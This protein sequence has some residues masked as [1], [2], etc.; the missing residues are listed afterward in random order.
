[1]KRILIVADTHCGHRA[2]LTPPEWHY[3]V[4]EDAPRGIRKRAEQRETLWNWFAKNVKAQGKFHAL[5]HLGDC[6]DGKGERSEGTELITSDREEQCRMAAQ[7]IKFANAA[8]VYMVRGTPYHTGAGEDWED[9]VAKE[10]GA[11]KIEDEGH[12]EVNGL[13]I[14]A[15][16]F[17]GNSASIVSKATAA[18]RAQANQQLWAILGQQDRAHI[19]LRAHI[20]RYLRVD[21][22]FGT[23]AVCPPL[24]GL[25]SRF[26]VRQR[27]GLPCSFGFLVLD[28]ESAERWALRRVLMPLS[29]QRGEVLSI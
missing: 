17:I 6:I 10:V 14:A 26:G 8:H 9:I 18:S 15:K 22:E 7:C 13:H 24:Q 2:G 29:M 16:H 12:Y 20:H 19:I 11:A 27:D 23:V 4:P 25:G 28:V 1:M 21:D 5:I 3:K